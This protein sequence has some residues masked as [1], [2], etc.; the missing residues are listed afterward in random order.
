M[1][2]LQSTSSLPDAACASQGN[3][4]LWEKLDQLLDEMRDL[5]EGIDDTV[6]AMYPPVDYATLAKHVSIQLFGIVQF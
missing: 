1:E 5:P 6:L 4:T 3:F 2:I